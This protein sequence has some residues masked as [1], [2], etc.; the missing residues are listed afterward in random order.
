[1]V[2]NSSRVTNPTVQTMYPDLPE[3]GG[4][5]QRCQPTIVLQSLQL[6]FS[7]VVEFVVLDQ[8]VVVHPHDHV[9]VLLCAVRYDHQGVQ[10]GVSL[11]VSVRHVC[12]LVGVIHEEGHYVRLVGASGQRQRKFSCWV[13]EKHP[14]ML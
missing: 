12:P 9:D 6:D 8:D 7:F 14:D 4:Q 5:L 1:M 3:L 13:E 2:S 10:D 11:G